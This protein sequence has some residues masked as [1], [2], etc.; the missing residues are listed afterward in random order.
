[1]RLDV[2]G[3]CA[4]AA[5]ARRLLSPCTLCPRNCRVRRL[6]G[7]VGPC[8]VGAVA[9]VATFGP[10]H[11]E[12]PPLSGSAGSGTVFL[13]GCNLRCL[14]CQNHDISRD[15][16]GLPVSPEGLAAIVLDLEARGCHNVN[17]VSPTHVMPQILDGLAEARRNGFDLPVVWNC[18]GFES[19]TVLRLL[20]GVVDIYMP[21]FKYGDE[22]DARRLSGV[23]SYPAH[24]RAALREMHRQVGDLVL[25]ARGIATRG[26][27]VRHLVLPGGRAGTAAVMRFLSA[28]ISRDTYVNVMD[29][30]RP[31][32][33][34]W[35]AIGLARG[36]SAAEIRD[37]AASARRAGLH[38]GIFPVMG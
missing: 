11:G 15:A 38:R 12:E 34:D 10:H 35:S 2:E 14:F 30:Y 27:L 8:R 25:D 21:D 4:R 17:F 32:G 18:G 7:E 1:M 37:A 29:Q 28:G 31:A 13:S 22:I 5:E 33:G 9:R 16:A 36:P 24:A 23:R 19:V 26:L 3:L 20:D 6:A